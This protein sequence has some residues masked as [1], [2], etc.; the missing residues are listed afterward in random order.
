MG[1][2]KKNSWG[3]S[4]YDPTSTRDDNSG[5]VTSNVSWANPTGGGQNSLYNGIQ[6]V[7]DPGGVASTANNILTLGVSPGIRPDK[8]QD[9]LL[10]GK[11]TLWGA[12]GQKGPVGN[13]FI[14]NNN[15][16]YNPDGT[17]K[18]PANPQASAQ[19]EYGKEEGYGPSIPTYNAP[20]TPQ[21][22]SGK[23]PDMYA[24]PTRP[25][26]MTNLERQDYE[27]RLR[28][29]MA[30]NIAQNKEFTFTNVPKQNPKSLDI[31]SIM[32][33]VKP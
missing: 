12:P 14:P 33:T 4:Y 29:A 10:T 6:N 2:W 32:N 22:V 18:D 7:L 25:G 16:A 20:S 26:Y 8:I 1:E 27:S 31:Q 5:G 11:G 21:S 13:Q 23:R 15:A 28:N 9:S 24:K 19:Y 30:G 3:I 17:P